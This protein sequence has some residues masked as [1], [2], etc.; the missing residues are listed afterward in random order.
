MSA[1]LDVELAAAKVL[2]GVVCGKDGATVPEILIK[3]YEGV[4]TATVCFI[5]V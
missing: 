3:H 1:L 5:L 4:I 2:A